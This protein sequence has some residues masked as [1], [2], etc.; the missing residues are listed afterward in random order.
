MQDKEIFRLK[1]Q[2]IM[3]LKLP[4]KKINK[5]IDFAIVRDEHVDEFVKDLFNMIKGFGNWCIDASKKGK[6]LEGKK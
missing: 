6:K 1:N 4:D 2:K 3:D 5:I